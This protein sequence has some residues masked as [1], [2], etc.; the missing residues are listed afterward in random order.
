MCM[1]TRGL[2]CS[3]DPVLLAFTELYKRQQQTG[4]SP[5]VQGAM[6]VVRWDVKGI[7]RLRHVMHSGLNQ[8]IWVHV[9]ARRQSQPLENDPK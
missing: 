4:I 3:A 7:L 5:D 9:H 6:R 8:R 1:C 2:C